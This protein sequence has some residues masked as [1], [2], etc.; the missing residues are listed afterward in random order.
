MEILL[1][2]KN[3]IAV[4]FVINISRK[5]LF[6]INNFL[7][8]LFFLSVISCSKAN[9]KNKLDQRPNIILLVADDLGY[10]DIG[11]YGGDIETP[12]IDNLAAKGIRFSSYHTAPLCAPTRAMLLTGNDN[13]I[14]G[15]GRQGLV[16]DEFGYEGR[17]TNRV[18]AIPQLLKKAGYHTYMAGKWHLG[19]SAESNPHQKGFEHS[20]VLIE[21][22]GNHYNDQGLFEDNP[23]SPYTEDGKTAKWKEGDYSTDFYTDKLIEYIDRH[24]ED[25][26]P[27]FAFAAY[28]SPHWPLQVDEKYWKKYEGRYAEGYDKLKEKRLKSLKKAGMIPENTMLPSNHE[29]IKYWNSL[30]GEEKMKESRKMELYA[31]MVDNLD[32]NIGRLIQYL[33]DIGEY[34][35][36]LIV[37]MSDNGADGSDFY[38]SDRF[39]PFIREHFNDDYK[40][41]GQPNSFISYGPQWAEAGTSPFKY[42]KGFTTEGGMTAAMIISGPNVERKNEIYHGLTTIMDIAPT[43]YEVAGID[44]PDTYEGNKLYP[45]RGKSIVPLASGK[46]SELHSDDYVFGLEHG[47]WAMIRKGKWKITN[48]KKPFST[49]NFELFDLSTDLGEQNDLKILEPEK[50]EELLKEWTKFSNEIKVQVPTPTED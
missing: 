11:C 44:Y 20:F 21:G 34:E 43:F 7:L 6:S 36:T 9:E 33:K 26:K 8:F 32:F 2:N 19:R 30:S 15:M 14:A 3:I 23:I 18:A 48:I 1:N 29:S 4:F 25:K 49:E 5:K 17:L 16:T 38:N 41:M 35:N 42:Y 31:G 12:N 45:M 27:F 10:A 22:A 46:A 39:G 13:H 40:T 24:K 47:N 28:T 37:F 50:Y